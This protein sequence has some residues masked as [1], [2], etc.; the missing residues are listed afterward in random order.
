LHDKSVIIELSGL[1]QISSIWSFG[2]TQTF[3]CT[4][5]V[6]LNTAGIESWNIPVAVLLIAQQRSETFYLLI[7]TYLL[8]F[9]THLFTTNARCYTI[10]I[11][12]IVLGIE[13][14][15]CRLFLLNIF[16]VSEVKKMRI[17]RIVHLCFV[18]W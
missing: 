13:I 6:G 18:M 15:F 2:F 12:I 11:N 8:A 10:T 7:F 17:M 16:M 3:G 4:I 1:L 9:I 5:G 14:S